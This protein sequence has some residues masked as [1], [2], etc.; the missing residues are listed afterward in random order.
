METTILEGLPLARLRFD[1]Q[2]REESV[3]HPFKGDLLRMALLWWLSTYWCKMPQVCRPAQACQNPATCAFGRLCEPPLDPTWP[4]HILRLIGET[5]P[6][7]YALWDLQDRRYHLMSGD[8]WAFELALVGEAALRELPA[9]VSAIREGAEQGMGRTRLHSSLERVSAPAP[10]GESVLLAQIEPRGHGA[11]WTWQSYRREDFVL[12]YR[13][14]VEWARGY[15]R[16]V[17]ALSLRYLSP[18]KIKERSQWVETPRFGAVMR[19]LVRR[20]RIL[21]VVH[22]AGEWPQTE[23]GALL[24]LA[25]AVHLEHDE[26]YW[27]GYARHSG[28]S[29]IH[30]VDGF[31]GQAWYT[32]P[33]MR[34]L[35]PALWLGQWLHIG[36]EYVLGNGRYEIAQLF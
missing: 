7:A 32:G 31:A 24:D 33:D 12:C 13:H 36:K 11:T 25:E 26:T 16:P 19:A 5:P 29:G 15:D 21:S 28:R 35:L 1:L 34:P 22:G 4:P 8:N 30:D 3:V 6:A 17:R 23:Y 14:A 2:A 10:S 27:C 9:F 20:L 18:V